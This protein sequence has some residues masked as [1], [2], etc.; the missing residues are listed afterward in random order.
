MVMEFDQYLQPCD[1]ADSRYLTG[2]GSLSKSRPLLDSYRAV[3]A[4][5]AVQSTGDQDVEGNV[6]TEKRCTWE[7]NFDNDDDAETILTSHV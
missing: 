6:T 5:V 3:A 7:C 2:Y 4:K 1:V